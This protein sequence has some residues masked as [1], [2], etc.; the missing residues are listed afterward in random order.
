M[1]IRANYGIGADAASYL[2]AA[3][4]A[5]LGGGHLLAALIKPGVDPGPADWV[6]V[7]FIGIG[8]AGLIG[9]ISFG[10]G[11]ILGAT[12]LF[13]FTARAFGRRALQVDLA[14]GF[15]LGLSIFL[16]FNKLLT[17]A[18]PMGPLERLL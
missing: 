11:F 3:F 10:G 8:L 2:V 14:I 6:G 13:A 12:L 7:T 9:A 17:L 5:L 4:L 18:L 1:E 16:L 15:G